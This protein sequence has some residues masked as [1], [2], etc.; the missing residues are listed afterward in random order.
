MDFSPLFTRDSFL[1]EAE[2]DET[3]NDAG[4]ETGDQPQE[5]ETTSNNETQEIDNKNELP[6]ENIK[7]PKND[8]S[9]EPNEKML[10]V[11]QLMML[12]IDLI[13]KCRFQ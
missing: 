8:T 4:N 11:K 1:L 5:T 2:D 10:I 6:S 13:W 3:G 9:N 12:I 7:E